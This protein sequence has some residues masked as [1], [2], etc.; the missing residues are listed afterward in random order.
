MMQE[1][2]VTSFGV[3]AIMTDF[4]EPLKWVMLLAVIIVF[5]D[6]RFGIR[7][8]KIRGETIRTSR[9]IRRTIN[10]IV[11]YACWILLAG[12][13]GEAFGEPFGIPM[14]PLIVL[15]VIFGCEVNSCFANYFES[16]G[17]KLKINIFKIFRSKAEILEPDEKQPD[18]TEKL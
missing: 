1:R 13:L 15:L 16:K 18:K 10:K 9:A 17:Q 11:D 7:A 2:N 6:L 14:L 3:I 8:A 5:V 4:F 12:V